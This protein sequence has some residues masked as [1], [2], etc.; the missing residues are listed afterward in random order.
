MPIDVYEMLL[1]VEVGEPG[2]EG[3]HRGFFKSFAGGRSKKEA[4][5]AARDVLHENGFRV[6]KASEVKRLRSHN[7]AEY[8]DEHQGLIAATC[9]D[10][11]PRFTP[12]YAY[13]PNSE[14]D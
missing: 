5:R 1:K 7:I 11:V 4:V 2:S 3:W 10:G 6:L 8:D 12:L 14:D 13:W 9:G